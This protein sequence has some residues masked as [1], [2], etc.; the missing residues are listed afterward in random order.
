[1]TQP[2]ET[3]WRL[4]GVRVRSG[5]EPVVVNLDIPVVEKPAEAHWVDNIHPAPRG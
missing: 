2:A 3:K 4:H 1:M 5:Q